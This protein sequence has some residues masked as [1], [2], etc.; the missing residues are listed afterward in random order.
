LGYT[1]SETKKIENERRERLEGKEDKKDY[2]LSITAEKEFNRCYKRNIVANFL[3]L[4]DIENLKKI[5][6][7]DID[8][9]LNSLKHLD[10]INDVKEFLKFIGTENIAKEHVLKNLKDKLKEN[11]NNLKI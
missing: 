6:G 10:L 1:V 2:S 4:V 7:L 5:G 8:A 11:K 9:N 3:S